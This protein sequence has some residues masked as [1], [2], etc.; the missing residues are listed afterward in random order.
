MET[1]THMSKAK[2][3]GKVFSL[4][5]VL[6]LCGLTFFIVEDTALIREDCENP[7]YRFIWGKEKKTSREVARGIYAD[8]LAL[9]RESI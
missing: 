9:I 1:L 6:D 8:R 3:T 4:P 7:R 2:E 5:P